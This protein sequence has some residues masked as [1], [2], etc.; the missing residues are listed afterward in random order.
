MSKRKENTGSALQKNV[1]CE[2]KK[3]LGCLYSLL[4]HDQAVGLQE[5]KHK[6]KTI[7]LDLSWTYMYGVIGYNFGVL[8]FFFF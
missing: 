2:E 8:A 4:Q 1:S 3:T 6:T 5:Q 7:P